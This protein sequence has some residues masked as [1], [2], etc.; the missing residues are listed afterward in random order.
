MELAS[1]FCLDFQ[2]KRVNQE[3][4]L[5]HSVLFSGRLLVSY[6]DWSPGQGFAENTKGWRRTWKSQLCFFTFF[7]N[8]HWAHAKGRLN[9]PPHIPWVFVF[10]RSLSP[11]ATWLRV[12][13]K[14]LKPVPLYFAKAS[15]CFNSQKMF[16]QSW[17]LLLCN[18]FSFLLLHVLFMSSFKTGQWKSSSRFLNKF[19]QCFWVVLS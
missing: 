18:C 10:Q 1:I 13:W 2:M 12:L 7:W 8:I 9:H 14:E 11:I 5:V 17:L 19:W 15:L 3:T 4:M 6:V 16:Y